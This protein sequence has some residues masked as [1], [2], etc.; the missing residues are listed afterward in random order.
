MS[1]DSDN[2]ITQYLLG[3]LPADEAERLDEL[4]ITDDGFAEALKVAENDLVDAYVRGE[5]TGWQLERFQSFY[6]AS[7]LRREK[8][9]FGNALRTFVDT[10]ASFQPSTEQ[11]TLPA[12]VPAAKRRSLWE[13]LTTPSRVLQFGTALATLALVIVG[14]WLVLQ[15]IRLRQQ[16]TATQ[17]RRDALTVREQQL[18]SELERERQA[19][20]SSQQE[21]SRVR[22]ER[23]QLEDQLSKTQPPSSL[24]EASVAV[25]RLVPQMRGASQVQTLSVLPQ[26]QRVATHLELEAT[27]YPVYR[28]ALVEASSDRVLWRS[29]LLKAGADKTLRVSF[30]ANLLKPQTYLM[31][32]SGVSIGGQSE[33]VADYPFRVAR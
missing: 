31:R 21:L 10:P 5:L 8:V 1:E 32:V 14:G 4:S 12:S 26:T 29:G 16:V 13:L 15:N 20:V 11:K 7:P 23:Q 19:S 28:V 3:T 6:L 33:T 25:V 18:L 17:M 9:K 2:K 22:E 30:P 27:D 24:P